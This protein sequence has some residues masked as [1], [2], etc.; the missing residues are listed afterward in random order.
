MASGACEHLE[1]FTPQLPRFNQTV[2][3]EECTQCF[4][5]Q[6]RR[7]SNSTRILADLWHR[8]RQQ[9]S[10]FVSGVSMAGVQQPPIAIMLRSTMS[11]GESITPSSSISGVDPKS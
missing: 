3:R 1:R 11:V 7:T 2:H 6:V 9:A 10:T 4:D 8:T 5:S